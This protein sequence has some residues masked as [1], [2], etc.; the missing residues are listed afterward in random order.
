[1]CVV[2]RGDLV[3]RCEVLWSDTS[4]RDATYGVV[5]R[6]DFA[7]VDARWGGATQARVER[8]K[9]GW[10]DASLSGATQAWV[11]R[12][13]VGC[14]DASLGGAT[15]GLS[16]CVDRQCLRVSDPRSGRE[17]L[18][19]AGLRFETSSNEMCSEVSQERY[20]NTVW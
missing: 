11:E 4:S 19:L 3:D 14:S 20:I 1:M 10:S 9:V 2:G 13:K 16:G 12:L 7:R 18:A 17:T 8:R 15:Q 5:E 6:R